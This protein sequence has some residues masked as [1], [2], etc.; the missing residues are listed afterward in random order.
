MTA[1]L[2]ICLAAAAADL[3]QPVGLSGTGID[4]VGGTRH[5]VLPGA[6]VE[7]VFGSQTVVG[8]TDEAGRYSIS[9]DCNDPDAIVFVYVQ[10][11]GNQSHVRASR[12]VD[13]CAAIQQSVDAGDEFQVGLVSSISTAAYAVLRWYIEDV[14]T[15]SWPPDATELFNHRHSVPWVFARR[16]MDAL[17]SMTLGKLPLPDGANAT[18]DVVVDRL[19]LQEHTESLV[20]AVGWEAMAEAYRAV[21]WDAGIYLPTETL[22]GLSSL[23]YYCPH[24]I[25]LC[26][27]S[28]QTFAGQ[29]YHSNGTQGGAADLVFRALQ[30]SVF[31]DGFRP[32]EDNLRAIRMTGES[33][34]PLSEFIGFITHPDFGQIERRSIVEFADLRLLDASEILPLGA[35]NQQIRLTYPNGEL[36]DEIMSGPPS[37]GGV[38]GNLYPTPSWSGPQPGE[39]WHMPIRLGSNDEVSSTQVFR[40]DRLT[41]GANGVGQSLLSGLSFQYLMNDG[42]LELDGPDIGPHRF[43]FLGGDLDRHALVKTTYRGGTEAMASNTLSLVRD[44]DPPAFIPESA[45]VRFFGGFDLDER[46]LIPVGGFPRAYLV[47]HLDTDGTGWQASMEDPS[48][49]GRPASSGDLSWHIDEHG[50]LVIERS[51]GTVSISRAWSPMAKHGPS[52]DLYVNELGPLIT[53]EVGHEFSL[54]PGRLNLYRRIEMA[55]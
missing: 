3:D 53:S 5:P 4:L 21:M 8:S 28:F 31:G 41:F 55:D 48:Q 23:S 16:V 1:G 2:G 35:V 15:L 43:R 37:P 22:L 29:P 39:S 47:F 51:F 27:A 17:P 14:D 26:E 12:V 18:L 11:S 32:P 6:S 42:V 46:N 33:G 50:R 45:P 9:V 7:L 38:I 52:G 25:S 40:W 44:N 13:S 30:D 36:P 49:P 10:G 54:I 19:L 20:A 34:A 24:L